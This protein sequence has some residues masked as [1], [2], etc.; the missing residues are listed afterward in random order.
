[1]CVSALKRCFYE[2]NLNL[3]SDLDIF[4]WEY[5][6]ALTCKSIAT[7]PI[8]RGS[9]GE[10]FTPQKVLQLLNKTGSM[11]EDTELPL[12]VARTDDLQVKLEQVGE[13]LIS[14]RKELS[15]YLLS[16]AILPAIQDEEV[17]SQQTRRRGND[18]QLNLGSICF[19]PI[20]FESHFNTTKAL[21]RLLRINDDHSGGLFQKTGPLNKN[22]FVHRNFGDLYFITAG[23]GPMTANGWLPTFNFQ[24]I[25]QGEDLSLT[26][27]FSNQNSALE[28]F[29]K[30]GSTVQEDPDEQEF[31]VDVSRKCQPPPETEPELP[32]SR[33]GRTLRPPDF[34]Q[35]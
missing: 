34:Y 5:L 35:A 1:M 27:E 31:F 19:C 29:D 10:Y 20:L 30:E 22:S 17:R 23:Q 28:F 16:A 25:L 8:C 3:R 2:Y 12:P 32:K 6:F 26:E 13:R 21:I 9:K 4:Q 24:D 33:Y 11:N 18:L 15:Y 7:R 14:L